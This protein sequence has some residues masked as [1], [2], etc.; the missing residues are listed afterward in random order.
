MRP[1]ASDYGT[2]C[3]D[4]QGCMH[5]PLSTNSHCSLTKATAHS[6]VSPHLRRASYGSVKR[7]QVAAV[8]TLMWFPIPATASASLPGPKDWKYP[9]TRLSR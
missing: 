1:G 2:V 5:S 4:V 6:A 3:F 8:P 9:S 7:M